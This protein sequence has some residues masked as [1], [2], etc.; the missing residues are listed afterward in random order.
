[1]HCTPLSEQEPQGIRRVH[2]NLYRMHRLQDLLLPILRDVCEAPWTPR[3]WRRYT[4]LRANHLS[5]NVQRKD[6]GGSLERQSDH[7]LQQYTEVAGQAGHCR[8]N[9]SRYDPLAGNLTDL[10]RVDEIMALEMGTT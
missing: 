1:M 7:A 9:K 4:S 6:F 5:H 10:R 8:A 2:F 3:L